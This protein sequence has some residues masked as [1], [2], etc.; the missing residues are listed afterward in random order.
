MFSLFSPG[1]SYR[2]FRFI[3]FMFLIIFISFST[4]LHTI[5]HIFRDISFRLLHPL[6]PAS[7]FL[8][9]F[10]HASFFSFLSWEFPPSSHVS[11]LMR[12]F[13][14]LCL[15][16][17]VAHFPYEMRFSTLFFTFYSFFSVILSQRRQRHQLAIAHDAALPPPPSPAGAAAIAL[18]SA[19]LS[20]VFTAACRCAYV[21]CAQIRYR[22]L[23]PTDW[24]WYF[25]FFIYGRDF[26]FSFFSALQSFQL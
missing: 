12:H 7:C 4:M 14:S 8:R 5:F 26:T 18:A 9:S 11:I 15:F 10:S 1:Y 6:M 2:S 20:P 25:L 24:A 22:S 3:I 16:R 21:R 13:L 19:L 17:R 23:Q